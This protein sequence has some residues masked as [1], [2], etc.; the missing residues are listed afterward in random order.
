[1]K[2]KLRINTRV[3]LCL[4]HTFRTVCVTFSTL[5][6]SDWRASL[7]ALLSSHPHPAGAGKEGREEEEEERKGKKA[8][9]TLI[10]S[11]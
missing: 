10:Q 11:L 3:L 5:H 8:S 4:S 6:S 1:M 9:E 7:P 2:P